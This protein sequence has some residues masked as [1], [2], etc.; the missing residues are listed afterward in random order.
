[1]MMM[2]MSGHVNSNITTSAMAHYDTLR[3]MTHNL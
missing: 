2:M 1:M 3:V